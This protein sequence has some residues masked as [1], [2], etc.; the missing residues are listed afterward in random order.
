MVRKF[1]AICIKEEHM[2]RAE[3]T[4]HITHRDL[5][6]VEKILTHGWPCVVAHNGPT[7]LSTK[8]VRNDPAWCVLDDDELG[9]LHR[10]IGHAFSGF[11]EEDSE[12]I[13]VCGEVLIT[14]MSKR[15]L[16]R[17]FID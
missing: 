9:Q 16:Q 13:R 1:R 5:G 4:C 7:D 14:R 15:Y 8:M 6:G 17:L 2:R 10:G 3:L 12:V 11:D